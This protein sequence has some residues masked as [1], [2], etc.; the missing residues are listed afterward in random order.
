MEFKLSSTIKLRSF[1]RSSSLG[2]LVAGSDISTFVPRGQFCLHDAYRVDRGIGEHVS[3]VRLGGM[4]LR[5]VTS[6]GQP[7]HPKNSTKDDNF[8]E[9]ARGV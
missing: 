4:G 9:V 1:L 6:R 7:V 2:A 8:V 5:C 3:C